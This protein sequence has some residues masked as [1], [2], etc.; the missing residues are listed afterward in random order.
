MLVAEVVGELG[1]GRS[2]SPIYIEIESG[3]MVANVHI[4]FMAR[5][6]HNILVELANISCHSNTS[7]LSNSFYI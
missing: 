6:H 5:N 4:F 7:H 3:C 2:F 1:G